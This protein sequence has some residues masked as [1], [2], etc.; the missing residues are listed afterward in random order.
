ML[1][2][3]K[4][5]KKSRKNR[6]RKIA[7]T[8]FKGW[9]S[10]PIG[11]NFGSRFKLPTPFFISLLPP[12]SPSTCFLLVFFYCNILMMH[13][14]LSAF[15]IKCSYSL[16]IRRRKSALFVQVCSLSGP[17]LAV[18]KGEITTVRKHRAKT[19]QRWRIRHSKE[20][21]TVWM[22]AV[23]FCFRVRVG[24]GGQWT[25]G[26]FLD[27]VAK[28]NI[29]FMGL[30]ATL[31]R[32]EIKFRRKIL[33]PCT[34]YYSKWKKNGSKCFSERL[35]NVF[36]NPGSDIPPP[37]KLFCSGYGGSRLLQNDD[38]RRHIPKHSNFPRR[39]P[40]KLKSQ[41]RFLPLT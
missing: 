40:K 23:V 31:C 37:K 7:S 22:Q 9:H 28:R 21:A 16:S 5:K 12:P 41:D 6:E 32:R 27:E 2:S 29:H 3:R 39:C 15:V 14:A 35:V 10:D 38:T 13:N 20:C 24:Y 8:C 17:Y 34:G 19:A 18:Y 33:P 4:N 25:L 30:D 36:Q 26:E 1:A 11:R